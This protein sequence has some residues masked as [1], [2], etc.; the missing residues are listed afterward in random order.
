MACEDADLLGTEHRGAS[1]FTN[2][3]RTA[4]RQ[5]WHDL[6]IR[7]RRGL[8][9]VMCFIVPLGLCFTLLVVVSLSGS[10]S[11]FSLD[12]TACQ[13]DGQFSLDS[14]DY[15]Y[16]DVSGFFQVT[17]GFGDLT[18]TQAKVIDVVWDV[19]SDTERA[20]VAEL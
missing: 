4:H 9:W 15:D 18:F 12:V 5:A 14:N 3:W 6:K 13:P 11:N 1:R 7:W 2:L 20:W 8:F 17:L 19:V 10:A 16:W